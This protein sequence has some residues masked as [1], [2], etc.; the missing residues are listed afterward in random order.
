MAITAPAPTFYF[1]NIIFNSSFYPST[2][3]GIT[4]TQAD[5]RYLIKISSDTAT[6]SE[7][8][9]LGLTSLNVEP[10][11]ITGNLTIAGTQT[12]GNLIIGGNQTSGSINIGY[13]ASASSS[14]T[15][16]INIGTLNTLGPS[17]LYISS[18]TAGMTISSTGYIYISPIGGST[19]ILKLQ[20]NAI[21]TIPGYSGVLTIGGANATSVVLGGSATTSVSFASGVTN[22]QLGN[23]EY[24][25]C[26]ASA[27]LPT[28]SGNQIGSTYSATV[29]SLAMISSPTLVATITLNQGVYI[30]TG[31]VWMDITGLTSFT[32]GFSTISIGSTDYGKIQILNAV[33]GG[34]VL[35]T[36]A[37][38]SITAASTNVLLYAGALYSGTSINSNGGLSRFSI[39]KIA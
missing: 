25:T 23:G 31:Y 18:G 4:Q 10:T 36:T 12:T 29:S 37:I 38:L 34:L 35:T 22:L 30:A 20:A 33:N 15:G 11:A 27:T 7:N 5:A 19:Q 32:R 17:P 3:T 26:G 28:T 8:F 39:V 24:I 6:S 14:L 2:S 9:N 13:N 1:N 21:D 16:T